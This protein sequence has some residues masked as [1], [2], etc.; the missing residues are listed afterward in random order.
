MLGFDATIPL[1]ILAALVLLAGVVGLI[2]GLVEGI[3]RIF[4]QRWRAAQRHSLQLTYVDAT[5]VKARCVDEILR[6]NAKMIRRSPTMR[7]APEVTEKMAVV[8]ERARDPIPFVSESPHYRKDGSQRERIAASAHQQFTEIRK[9][10]AQIV[11]QSERGLLLLLEEIRHQSPPADLARKSLEVFA[12]A[13]AL[14]II[15]A[16]KEGYDYKEFGADAWFQSYQFGPGPGMGLLRAPTRSDTGRRVFGISW[17]V[18]VRVG[19]IEDYV[20]V[21]MP[22]ALASRLYSGSGRGHAET[23]FSWVLPQL[24]LKEDADQVL[25]RFDRDYYELM[26]PTG[27]GGDE[28][29]PRTPCPWPEALSAATFE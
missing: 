17:F 12:A 7:F 3:R 1:A 25:R 28:W 5:T 18:T 24:V 23:F 14:R 8:D 15:S 20:L 11:R 22:L 6:A 10:T 13:A 2:A 9:K 4:P 27:D 26:Q 19:H 21:S 29:Q 16:L